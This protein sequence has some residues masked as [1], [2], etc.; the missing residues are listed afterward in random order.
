MLFALNS[1]L[2]LHVEGHRSFHIFFHVGVE[3]TLD[4]GINRVCGLVVVYATATN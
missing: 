3:Q 2:Y 4:P 1:Q